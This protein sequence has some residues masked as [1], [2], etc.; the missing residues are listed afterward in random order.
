MCAKCQ[1]FDIW[2]IKHQKPSHLRCSK[3]Q[4]IWPMWVPNLEW[5]EQEWYMKKLIYYYC[6]LSSHYFNLLFFSLLSRFSLSTVYLSFLLALFSPLSL[7]LSQSAIVIS[8]PTRLAFVTR[9]A[10]CLPSD[11]NA[12]HYLL[13]AHFTSVDATRQAARLHWNPPDLTK[14]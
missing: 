14:I 11:A 6:S 13:I 12:T 2:H 4:K 9:P 7:P 8:P 1:I 3:Y 10:T 5:Y